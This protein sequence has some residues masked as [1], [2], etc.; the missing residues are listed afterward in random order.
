MLS[1]VLDESSRVLRSED[2]TVK[3]KE[4]KRSVETVLM[5]AVSRVVKIG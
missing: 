5:S 3:K 1:L 4:K 2:Y